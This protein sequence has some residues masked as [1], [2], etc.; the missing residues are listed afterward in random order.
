MWQMVVDGATV[1][2]T[3]GFVPSSVVVPDVDRPGL[4]RA[5][6]RA[7]APYARE[8][9]EQ[10]VVPA[11]DTCRDD[12]TLPDLLEFGFDIVDLSP[13]DALQQV[14]ARVRQAGV[15]SDEDATTIRSSLQG[16]AL[17]CA[18]GRT[19]TVLHVADEGLIMRKAG[20][21]GMAVVGPRSRGM[22][23]HGGATSVHADQDVFGTPLTQL[24]DG[25]APSLFR[26]DSPDGANRDAGLM[27]VNLWIPLQ[28]ITQPLVLADGRSID[29]PRHQLRYGLATETFLEREDDMAVNDIWT[30]LH[31]PDQRWYLR[32]A[33]EHSR[34]YVFDTLSTAHG[35]C[36]L[37]GEDV[38]ER[39]Y[40]SLEDAEEAV[41]AG[42]VAALI[43]AVAL[44]RQAVPPIEA[45]PALR[46]AID[47][48]AA[49]AVEAH[50]DP[51]H[52]CGEGAEA[53][54]TR[55]RAERRRVVRMSLEMRMVVS[56][57][58]R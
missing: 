53:W 6:P 32:S 4:L 50:A 34:A 21:N 28:Q 12:A 57:D 19:I 54:L 22:N 29:R 40:R 13:L 26:H 46:D 7:A 47:A 24:M 35:A 9:V 49:A 42:D 55:S 17:R 41:T 30:F 5:G 3:I 43:E 15:V 56:I 44:V 31:H 8:S 16:A 58:G 39:L 45:P 2:V 52:T 36:T 14:C 20:P 48:M 51:A 1:P 37:P 18:D 25:R 11:I 23:D 33:M 27:L 38:A 10:H